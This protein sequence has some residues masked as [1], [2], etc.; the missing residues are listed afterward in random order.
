MF[1]NRFFKKSYN[2]TYIFW[3]RNQILLEDKNQKGISPVSYI[4]Y[5]LYIE[6]EFKILILILNFNEYCQTAKRL[7]LKSISL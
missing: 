6:D 5:I 3:Y 1:F 2:S 7:Y 4:F